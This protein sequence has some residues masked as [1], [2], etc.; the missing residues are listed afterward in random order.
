MG[1]RPLHKIILRELL[2]S[3]FGG[4][5]VQLSFLAGSQF[6]R[7]D[8]LSHCKQ[9]SSQTHLQAKKLKFK[10][11]ASYSKQKDRVPSSVFLCNRLS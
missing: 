8:A 9:K 10:Q 11:E 4:G 2:C 3:H 5:G 6:M 1:S 7:L